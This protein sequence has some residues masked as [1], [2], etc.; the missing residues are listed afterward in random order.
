MNQ[1]R[2]Y[3]TSRESCRLNRRELFA[4]S[5]GISLG[6]VS[7][8]TADGNPQAMGQGRASQR[9]TPDQIAYDYE[10]LL[11]RPT[12]GESVRNLLHPIPPERVIVLR[13]ADYSED[14]HCG[15][16][17]SRSESVLWGTEPS[18]DIGLIARMAEILTTYH[19]VP[20]HR[21]SW[22]KTMAS[23][24][25]FG[26]SINH[27]GVGIVRPFQR[28]GLVPATN[29]PVDWW[30]FLLSDGCVDW[31]DEGNELHTILVQVAT[32]PVPGA[33]S[34]DGLFLA[35]LISRIHARPSKWREVTRMSRDD[36]ARFVNRQMLLALRGVPGQ[37]RFQDSGA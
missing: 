35:H 12:S 8:A 34:F 33:R 17:I 22:V 15:K 13:M 32:D 30:L 11:G 27:R 26:P 29:S 23:S 2:I 9:M 37:G 3:T 18:V 20:E 4:V 19:E 14:I 36:A 24:E 1:Y 28:S 31:N 25:D 16:P 10:H 7:K 21:R 5:M 6:L